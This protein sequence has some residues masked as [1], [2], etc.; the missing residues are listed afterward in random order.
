M[1]DYKVYVLLSPLDNTVR[2]IGITS[3]TLSRRLKEHLKAKKR[4]NIHKFH[5][6]QKLKNLNLKPIIQLVAENLSREEACALEIQLIAKY[7][8]DVG[9]KLLNVS[10]G[11]F[12]PSEETRKRMSE[13]NSGSNHY[14]YGKPLRPEHRKAVSEALKGRIFTNEHRRK[15]SEASKG[16]PKPEVVANVLRQ[17]ALKQQK[18][19]QQLTRDGILVAEF[20]SITEAAKQTGNDLALISRVCKGRGKTAGGFLWRFR[21]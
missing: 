3:T 5:Y 21:S 20:P 11:G 10:P 14:N 18:P 4:N 13:A 16:K 9:E 8:A 7:R 17:E 2:Y 15:Q 6:I 19:V 12:A 1:S